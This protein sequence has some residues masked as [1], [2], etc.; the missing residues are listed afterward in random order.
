SGRQMRLFRRPRRSERSIAANTASRVIIKA[1]GLAVRFG[2]GM[3]VSQ[4]RMLE[5]H[6]RHR[7][8]G[9]EDG[10]QPYALSGLFGRRC[11]EDAPSGQ[12]GAD[13]GNL[14]RLVVQDKKCSTT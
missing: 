14:V 2:C 9:T 10:A 8:N 12:R 6:C 5:A 1:K 11:R 3:S 7:S 4:W 13:V